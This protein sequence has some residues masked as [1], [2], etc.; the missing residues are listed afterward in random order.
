MSFLP[1]S[2]NAQ[3]I[4]LV[5]CILLATG[6][7]SGWLTARNQSEMLNT[8][9][10]RNAEIMTGNLGDRCAYYLV[11]QD[12]AGLESFLGQATGRAEIRRLQVCDPDGIV[13][14]DVESDSAGKARRKTG[15]ARLVPPS[16]TAPLLL[17]EKGELVIWQPI[18]A[19]TLVGWLKAGYSLAAIQKLERATR[20]NGLLLSLLWVAGSIALLLLVLR[21]AVRDVDRLVE[22]ARDLDAHKGAQL[23]IRPGTS[24]LEELGVSLNYASTRLLATAQELIRDK[25][26]LQ[27][28]YA[29]IRGIIDSA[30][31]PIFSVDRQYRYT[32]F[33]SAHAS[34]MQT[35]YG[36]E[37]NVGESQLE[38]IAVPEDREKAQQNLD[39]TLA[40]EH[41]VAT[42][43][44]GADV[45]ARRYLEVSHSPIRAADGSVIGVAV[46]SRDV[47]ERKRAEDELH[48]LNR[49][50]RAISNCNQTL[51]R[52]EDEP[53]LLNAICR[54]VCDEAGYR[55]AWVGYAENDGAR[56]IRPVAW[57]GVVEGYL[58]QA[59]LIWAD[60]ERGQGP[61]G[62]AIRNGESACIQDFS[63]DPKA[64]PWRDQ[65]LQRG[66]RS[67]IAMPL[68]DEGKTTF[69]VLNIY[70]PEINAFT[71]DE[72]QLLEELAGDLAFGITV[73]R[74]R[75]ERK[76]VEDLLRAERGLFVE[77]PT[78]VFKWQN[79][80]G[81]P[82]EYVSP[83][84]A[85]QFG[86]TPEDLTS[87]KVPYASIV[88]PDDLARVGAE[89]SAFSKQ[90]LAS[91]D[92][93]YRIAHADGLYCWINDFT[94]VI[95]GQD[96][97]ITHYLG[98]ILKS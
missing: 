92:Q 35:L 45:R 15:A 22:F 12:Y 86:Y 62:I 58:E 3:L 93:I 73:L 39:R 17:L 97:A 5:S 33:N 70:S 71:P 72:I 77:G 63:T 21:P 11:L 48:R 75:L 32:S 79:R 66:Y 2:L 53:T 23:A 88:H 96:G 84:V 64:S 76:R 54:I 40:G 60:T 4:L 89:V 25:E 74:A 41:F 26:A 9:M 44:F 85:A 59:G 36:R 61:S 80:E 47:T 51:M 34:V 42:A 69:G 82:V 38:F 30:D 7:M 13:V 46:F 94:T 14:G 65:A 28:Q 52:A 95:R 81:W 90:G 67:S 50:L 19:G 18:E 31:G 98:Y 78:V 91:F 55:M 29:T 49:E 27:E 1:R 16:Q 56:T 8:A 57:A 24:E 6:A 20:F 10:R 37:I 83:N 68:K 87:G 43:F